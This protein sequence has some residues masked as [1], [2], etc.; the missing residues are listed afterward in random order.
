MP[1]IHL[2]D[3]TAVARMRP[4]TRALTKAAV[5]A[6]HAPSIFNTQPWQWTIHDEQAELR[7]DRDRH[8]P[9]VDPQGRLLTL[10]CGV[11]LHHARVALAGTGSEPHVERFPD[12]ADPD[13]FA[14][15]TIAGMAAPP[16]GTVRLHQAIALRHTDRR[17]FADQPVSEPVLDRLRTAAESQ[18]AH[19]HVLR[20]DDVVLLTAAASHAADTELAS[21]AYRAELAAWTDRPAGSGDGVPLETAGPVGA[22]QVP[23]R[24]FAVAGATAGAQANAAAGATAARPAFTGVAD[25]QARYAVLYTDGDDPGSWLAAGEALSAVLL[26]ATAE[27]LGSSPMS[28]VVEVPAARRVLYDLL[29]HIGHPMLALRLGIPATAG[30]PGT[31]APRLAGLVAPAD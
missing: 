12:R 11:A 8:L 9:V 21:P 30:P 19:L 16:P 22:R 18:G 17:P 14:V 31:V 6:Q 15:L 20:P 4:A 10:S 24:D 23:L 26:T 13:L 5:A 1:S 7:P 29:S 2:T 25:R 28:D 3:P 27:R